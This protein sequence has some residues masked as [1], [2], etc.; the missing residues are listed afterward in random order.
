M[1]ALIHIALIGWIPAVLLIF[2]MLPPR[3]AVIASFLIGWLFLPEW[4]YA[5]P[6]LPDYSKMTATCAGVLLATALFDPDRYWRFRL[7]W[8]DLPIAV[9]CLV[10]IPTALTNG[11]GLREGLSMAVS[12][13][14]TWA[15]PY[16]IG[17]LYFSD[18]IGLRELAIGY[19]I[20][21]FL[22]IPLCLYEI[23]MSP[24]LHR[25]IYGV[26]VHDWVQTIRYGGWRPMVFMRHG[27]MVGAWMAA[28]SLAATW[29]WWTG[30]W[31]RVGP[32]PLPWLVAAL[33]VTTVLCK[34]FGAI[35]LLLGALVAL[36]LATRLKTALPLYALLLFPVFY[37][38]TRATNIWSGDN[39]VAA[40]QS[41]DADRAASLEYRMYNENE[42]ATRARQQPIFGWGGWAR[43]RPVNPETGDRPT[44]DG[45]WIIA[46]GMHGAVGLT[47]LLAMLLMPP[48]GLLSVFPARDWG[49]P[50]LSGAVVAAALLMLYAADNLSNAMINPVFMLSAGALTTFVAT[51]RAARRRRIGSGVRF[52]GGAA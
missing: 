11:L 40:V 4:G 20:G 32:I 23:K 48:A 12:A 19:A 30:A 34:S 50:R 27:L 51:M 17:R 22:Y 33:L 21:G 43:Y 46:F 15:A 3:R 7:S 37:A 8:G 44:P 25:M 14:I 42:M 2:L 35:V 24:Q 38:T 47:A 9:W 52:A 29:L 13:I 41:I 16:F 28:A 10:G 39:L 36:L 18:W 6:G 5:L 49:D 26:F 45:L 31:R 1:T